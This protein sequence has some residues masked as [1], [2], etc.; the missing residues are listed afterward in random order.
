M[1]RLVDKDGSPPHYYKLN[2]NQESL[3]PG[4]TSPRSTDDSNSSSLSKYPA[5]RSWFDDATANSLERRRKKSKSASDSHKSGFCR[6]LPRGIKLGSSSTNLDAKSTSSTSTLSNSA[7]SYHGSDVSTCDSINLA[8]NNSLPRSGLRGVIWNSTSNSSSVS[9]FLSQSDAGEYITKEKDSSLHGQFHNRNQSSE[10]WRSSSSTVSDAAQRGDL[11]VIK[12]LTSL[13]SN[14]EQGSFTAPTIL[15]VEQQEKEKEITEKLVKT[16]RE[17]KDIADV[18]RIIDDVDDE[19]WLLVFIGELEVHLNDLIKL[20]SARSSKFCKEEMKQKETLL[21]VAMDLIRYLKERSTYVLHRRSSPKFTSLVPDDDEN[22]DCGT[23]KRLKALANEKP[24]NFDSMSKWQR[25]LSSLAGTLDKYLQRLEAKTSKTIDNNPP[26]NLNKNVSWVTYL[27]E[28]EENKTDSSASLPGHNS[29]SVFGVVNG[30]IIKLKVQL[31]ES[32]GSHNETTSD[33]VCSSPENINNAS[34]DNGRTSKPVYNSKSFGYVEVQENRETNISPNQT[35]SLNHNTPKSLGPHISKIMEDF[36]R[37]YENNDSLSSMKRVDD[38]KESKHVNAPSTNSQLKILHINDDKPRGRPQRG[39]S[40]TLKSDLK[41]PDDVERDLTKSPIYKSA[42]IVIPSSDQRHRRGG[43]LDRKTWKKERDS[44]RTWNFVASK[45]DLFQAT[46]PASLT[47]FQQY[48]S[49]H[50]H[51]INKDA[52]LVVSSPEM[53]GTHLSKF[54]MK[55][56][57]EHMDTSSEIIEEEIMTPATSYTLKGEL[58]QAVI[59]KERTPNTICKLSDW[60][61][62]RKE[63]YGSDDYGSSTSQGYSSDIS[64]RLQPTL[65]TSSTQCSIIS[66]ERMKKAEEELVKLKKSSSFLR[67]GITEAREERD[68]KDRRIAILESRIQRMKKNIE[69]GRTERGSVEVE[70][71]RMRR[72]RNQERRDA[73]IEV[74]EMQNRLTDVEDQL[75]RQERHVS[76]LQQQLEELNEEKQRTE[77]RSHQLESENL[78]MELKI[79][80]LTIELMGEKRLNRRLQADNVKMEEELAQVRDEAAA[81]K[82]GNKKDYKDSCCQTD[83]ICMTDEASATEDQNKDRICQLEEENESLSTENEILRATLENEKKVSD[84][85]TDCFRQQIEYLSNEVSLQQE[86]ARTQKVQYE[87][88]IDR[89]LASRSTNR[90]TPSLEDSIDVEV[91]SL[92]SQLTYHESLT[93]TLYVE[94]ERLRQERDELKLEHEQ[95][96][97]ISITPYIPTPQNA[98]SQEFGCQVEDRGYT[99]MRAFDFYA[100]EAYRDALRLNERGRHLQHETLHQSMRTRRLEVDVVNKASKFSKPELV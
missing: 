99:R 57:E 85:A 16:M 13:R 95:E 7:R 32:D 31:C 92:R 72:I 67:R 11:H 62:S 21:R 96:E 17:L 60:Q 94:N 65:K 41:K 3:P 88:E 84:A 38:R 69:E 26:H 8:L 2:L 49:S 78:I 76:G 91:T 19:E 82:F 22:N 42:V 81:L 27:G 15:Q 86:S 71:E 80:D 1:T 64:S 6:T 5:R 30:K 24:M 100:Q 79:R 75:A 9:S 52:E 35:S 89:L 77:K 34:R 10:E 66:N 45:D 33:V 36:S 55:V 93:R 59:E 29:T 44:R 46:S 74:E 54:S 98:T 4:P 90:S 37:L 58:E 12:K 48:I 14:Y 23:L 53:S 39:R 56:G 50:N 18:A 40:T 87:S 68:D 83:E 97:I 25:K 47:E 61:S 28:K 43:S 51:S 20:D 63:R 70:L 73:H